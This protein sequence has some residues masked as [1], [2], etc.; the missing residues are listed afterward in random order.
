MAL[1]SRSIVEVLPP[2][3]CR[4]AAGAPA[5]VRGLFSYRGALIPLVDAAA[6]LG[7]EPEPDRM[8]NRVIVLRAS[9]D[10]S[11]GGPRVGL[12]VESVLEVDYID[13]GAAGGHPGF[14]T[15][16]GRFLG[17]VTQTRWG[18]VQQVHPEH[19]FTAEQAIILRERSAGAAP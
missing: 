7:H 8:S 18:H 14:A 5:W 3:S 13:F 4:P 12:W 17:Q 11:A 6:V 10:G 9:A 16:A 1:D 15:Q 2:V 19:L